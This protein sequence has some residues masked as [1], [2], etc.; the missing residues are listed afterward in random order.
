MDTVRSIEKILRFRDKPER[1]RNMVV[2]EKV[3]EM[4]LTVENRLYPYGK[5][6]A[7]TGWGNIRISSLKMLTL[8][9]MTLAQQQKENLCLYGFPSEQWEVNL[10][11]E[12]VPPELPE[13]ALGINF[14]RDGMPEND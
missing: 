14:P 5:T 1:N 10:P 2:M 12:E 13:P 3:K 11:A 6:Y 7:A 9:D 4:V 8:L